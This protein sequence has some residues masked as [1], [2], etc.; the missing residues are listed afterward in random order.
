MGDFTERIGVIMEGAPFRLS[1]AR[2]G[3]EPPPPAFSGLD[4]ASLSPFLVNNDIN[5][6]GSYAPIGNNAS[7]GRVELFS[8]LGE[9]TS[10][11]S[12]HSEKDQAFGIFNYVS[13]PQGLV[14]V[15]NA[16]G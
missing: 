10:E 2:E 9:M 7:W 1:V 12:V 8:N 5:Y 13:A 4:T 14:T 15:K 6:R 16:A 3:P 11:S